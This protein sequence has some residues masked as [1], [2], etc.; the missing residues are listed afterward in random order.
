MNLRA[1]P[2]RGGILASR[3]VTRAFFG[4]SGTIRSAALTHGHQMGYSLYAF[5]STGTPFVA[6]PGASAL[7]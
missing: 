2:T 4:T 6:I 1:R 3:F 7:I 5:L